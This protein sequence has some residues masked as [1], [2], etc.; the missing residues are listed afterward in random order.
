MEH[1]S[2]EEDGMSFCPAIESFNFTIDEL[3]SQSCQFNQWLVISPY[4]QEEQTAHKSKAA[5]CTYIGSETFRLLCSLCALTK[6]EEC[7]YKEL[8]EKMDAH[9]GSKHL[10]LVER[11]RFLFSC[12]SCLQ[13]M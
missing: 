4:S 1:Y 10:V 9:S 6:P 11:F 2:G 13:A 7:T 8:H 5:F 12:E 3:D